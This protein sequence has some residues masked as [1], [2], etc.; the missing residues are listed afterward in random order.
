MENFL[1]I[2]DVCD[3][4]IIKIKGEG[5][6]VSL[7]NLKLQKLLYYTQAWHLAF[8][9]KPLFDGKFEAWVHGPVN[10]TIFNRFK[11]TK[12]LYSQIERQDVENQDALTK[13][14]ISLEQQTH[15]ESVLDEYAQFTGAQLEYMTHTEDPWLEA[16]GSLNPA[17]ACSKIISEKTMENY[18]K[19]RLDG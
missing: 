4:I 17:A 2:N 11:D 8:E 12:M 5:K 9:G 15:I 16:R 19:A 3:Y 10:R 13:D 7:T 1:N 6:H 14:V 18:Y